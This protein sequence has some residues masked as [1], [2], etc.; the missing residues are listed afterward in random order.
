M[1]E[2]TESRKSSLPLDYSH[3]FAAS[4][5]SYLLALSVRLWALEEDPKVQRVPH[6]SLICETALL[7]LPWVTP[8]MQC[9]PRTPEIWGPPPSC[10]PNAA[11]LR[12]SCHLISACGHTRTWISHQDHCSIA[13]RNTFC[14]ESPFAFFSQAQNSTKYDCRQKLLQKEAFFWK[15]ISGWC[16][17][18]H[19]PEIQPVSLSS[20]W[21]T[22][23]Q[24]IS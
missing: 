24:E 15:H 5:F 19:D 6:G 1:K 11:P 10:F 23:V 3:P 17:L 20:T 14:K 2:I 18:I 7:G 8:E 21:F 13:Q 9:W 12:P 4:S 16:G 22:L